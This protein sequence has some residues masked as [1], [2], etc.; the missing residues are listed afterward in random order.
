MAIDM[1]ALRAKALKKNEEDRKK[2]L[3]LELNEGNVQVIFNRCIATKDSKE[4]TC[5][6]LFSQKNGYPKDSEPVMFDKAQ[7]LNNG[8]NIEYLFGQLQDVRSSK[9]EFTPSSVA[10]NYHGEFWTQDSGLILVFLHLGYANHLFESFVRIPSGDYAYVPF[11]KPPLP[12]KDPDFPAWWEAH[13]AEWE[14]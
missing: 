12:P 5:P 6:I 2:F 9:H 3:P 14:A 7:I 13:K 8:K 1:N 4:L 11:I 10:V